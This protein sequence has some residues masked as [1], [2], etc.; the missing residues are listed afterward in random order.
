MREVCRRLGFEVAHD[1]VENV[2]KV[3]IQLA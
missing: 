1:D 2:V 3:A